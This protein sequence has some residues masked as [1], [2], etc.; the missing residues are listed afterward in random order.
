MAYVKKHSAN[1]Q[2]RT[3][4]QIMLS[5]FFPVQFYID[6]QTDLFP[7]SFEQILKMEISRRER[8]RKEIDRYVS[9]AMKYKPPIRLY[10]QFYISLHTVQNNFYIF[11]EK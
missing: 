11:M 10:L 8:E 9:R 3:D 7:F 4:N 5:P 6:P 1:V 2:K